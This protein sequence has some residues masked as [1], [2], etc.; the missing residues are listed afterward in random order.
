MMQDRIRSLAMIGGLVAA[1]LTLA[2]C[3]SGTAGQ[4]ATPGS[5]S[6]PSPAASVAATTS[7]G[8]TSPAGATPATS[9]SATAASVGAGGV[10]PVLIVP[11][12]GAAAGFDGQKPTTIDV[13]RDSSNIVAH[14]TWDTWGPGGAVG[15]G[16]AALN[17]CK[18]NCAQ[19]T[20]TKVPATIHLGGVTGGHFTTMTENAGN[21]SRSYTYPSN[22]VTGAS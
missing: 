13:S 9:A 18:P 16:T 2:G 1:A 7:S 10:G 8:P 11:A 3:S 6:P 12:F 22:W 5:S 20:I 19:G 15:H 4:A 17:N 21:L 14:L